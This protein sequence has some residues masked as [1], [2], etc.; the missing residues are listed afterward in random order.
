MTLK[1]RR[2]II[3]G[4]VDLFLSWLLITPPS[5]AEEPYQLPE[6]LVIEEADKETRFTADPTNTMISRPGT[7]EMLKRT[8]GANVNLNGPLTGIAQYRGMFGNRVNVLVDGVNINSGG[9]NAMDPPLHYL[10]R[11]RVGELEIIRGISPVSSGLE[12]IGG[13]VIANPRRGRF[14]DTKAFD[15]NG[16]LDGG[17]QSVDNGYSVGGVVALANKRHRFE[18]GGSRED[19]DDTRFG[20]GRIASTAYERNTYDLGYDYRSATQKTGIRFFHNDT[21]KTGTPALPMDIVFFDSDFING[22][23][24][25]DIGDLDLTAKLAYSNIDHQMN[26][27]EQREPPPDTSWFRFTNAD[28]Q[29]WYYTLDLVIPLWGGNLTFGADGN[30]ANHNATIFNPNNATFF[31]Q[32]FNY[33]DRDRLGF[34]GQWRSRVQGGWG[35]ELGLRYTRVEMNAGSVDGTPAQMLPG[36]QILR[37]R[38]N[39]ANR[40]KKDNNVDLVAKLNYRL[41]PE[42]RVELGLA[43]KTRSPMYQ[44]RYLWLPLQSTG[45]LADGNNYVGNI[46]LE[47]EIAYQL[48]L[49]LDWRSGVFYFSPH[50]FYQRV[51]DY[52]QGTPS[53]DPTVIMVSTA[54]GDPTP[55]QFNNV[56]AEFYGLDLELGYELISNLHVV[57]LFSYVRGTRRDIDDNIYRVAPPNGILSLTYERLAWSAT[58]EGEFYAEQNKVSKTNAETTSAGY[59]LL[60]LSACYILLESGRTNATLRA[61]IDNVLDKT[62]RPHLNGINRVRNSDVAVGGRLPGPGRNFYARLN[63]EF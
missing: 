32:N 18:A 52:I 35:T 2:L 6:L 53:D 7:A 54:N 21:G 4:P 44:E 60:N 31:V 51:D 3:A 41:R 55:L 5:G 45:G 63:V 46:D 1:L 43:R 49:A 11:P 23:Y 37:D 47:P 26:N 27:F 17:A 9:P 62:Y 39:N 40:D 15:I 14:G 8:S 29:A 61:G 25:T 13:T 57:G 16:Y 19:G 59:G 24:H 12:T 36:P 38:F 48:E 10:P 22:Q 33:I 28:S 56:D 50:T 58:L 20:G 34:F 30:L 42:L